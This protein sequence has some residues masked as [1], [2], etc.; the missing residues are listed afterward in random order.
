MK[1]LPIFI[2]LKNRTV[3]V[4]GGG[5]IA[6]RKIDL[7]IKTNA[8]I[9]IIAKK[10]TP[11]LKKKNNKKYINWIGHKFCTNKLIN[12]F[13]I[14]IATNNNKLNSKIFFEANKRKI[15][16]NTVDNPKN[17]SFIFPSIINRT[18]LLIAISSCGKAPILVKLIREKFESLL[19]F[20]LGKIIKITSKWREKIKKKIKSIKI[21]RYFWENIFSKKFFSLILNF[22]YNNAENEIIKNFKNFKIK[23]NGEI[24]LV[25][26]GPGDVG[27]LTIKGLQ[28]IQQ[29]DVVLYDYLI[30]K[31]ILN[32][33][34]RDAKRICV[35]KRIGLHSVLQK[36][37]NYLLIYLAK[38]GKRVVRLKGGDPFIFGRGAEE[39]KLV[40]KKNIKFN[41]VP[42][43][44]AANG[45]TAYAGI[46]LTHRK[47]SQS[48]T[49]ITGHNYLNNNLNF[50]NFNNKKHTF[51]IY[52][53]TIKINNIIKKMINDG[54]NKNLPIAIISKGTYLNQNI[55]ISTLK[56]INYL[57]KNI[58]LPN[59]IIIGE[60]VKLHYKL[61]WYKKN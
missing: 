2:N 46:P 52:M 32:L 40:Y 36:K 8:K 21:R 45:V 25:G 48:I 19:P 57:I 31:E 54:L 33:I 23:N 50:L 35:G 17:C 26:A 13:L 42:G 12:V 49:F 16:T 24:S 39:L 1:Y 20:K 4:I 28:V 38:S 9:K 53:G 14:I 18:P 59:L 30:N 56:K 6:S 7:L 60:V 3:L 22:Q 44:T 37:I 41:V 61:H 29:A 58:E 15:F 5:S 51:V 34:R 43:I 27:L 11:E 10:L 47:Y 55:I